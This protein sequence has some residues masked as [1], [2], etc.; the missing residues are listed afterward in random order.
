[1]QAIAKRNVCA[2][3]EGKNHKKLRLL[4]R[5]YVK[6]YNEVSKIT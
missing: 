6:Y 3:F 1:M 2:K 4:A 5:G